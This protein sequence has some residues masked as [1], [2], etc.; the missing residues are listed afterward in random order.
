MK[1]NIAKITL[2]ILSIITFLAIN[3]NTSD[4]KPVAYNGWQVVIVPTQYYVCE[5]PHWLAITCTC[6]IW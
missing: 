4:A 1:N 2:I 5:C 3:I 6:T